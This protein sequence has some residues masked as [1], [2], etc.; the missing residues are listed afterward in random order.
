MIYY[1]INQLSVYKRINDKYIDSHS[2][3]TMRKIKVPL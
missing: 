1:K 2:G 3:R